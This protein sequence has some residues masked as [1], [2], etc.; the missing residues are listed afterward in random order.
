MSARCRAARERDDGY[1]SHVWRSSPV[2]GVIQ[3]RTLK[4][5]DEENLID[6]ENLRYTGNSGRQREI[7][8]EIEPGPGWRQCCSRAGS[9]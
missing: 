7:E 2:W 3:G 9:L 8:I 1:I 6:R 5:G 4:S